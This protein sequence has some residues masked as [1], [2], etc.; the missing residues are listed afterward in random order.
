MLDMPRPEDQSTE[1][2]IPAQATIIS[3]KKRFLPWKNGAAMDYP[4]PEYVVTSLTAGAT[5]P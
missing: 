3:V 2:W 4:L 5:E 1:E